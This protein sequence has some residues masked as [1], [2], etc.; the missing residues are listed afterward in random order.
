[1]RS[2]TYCPIHPFFIDSI[3]IHALRAECDGYC[4]YAL[5][6]CANF[7]PRTPCGVRLIVYSFSIKFS[8]FQ[9]THS[10][11]SATKAPA[12]IT[13]QRK[14]FNPRTPCGVRPFVATGFLRRFEISIHALR[15]ECDASVPTLNAD[16]VIS[17]HALRAE[18][19]SIYC[20]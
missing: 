11:R 14:N 2:A 20:V 13:K 7:N 9:S 19:D 10:V 3:S 17:I 18:C 12:V 5:R 8:T 16:F 15:A 1:M 6:Q 4:R